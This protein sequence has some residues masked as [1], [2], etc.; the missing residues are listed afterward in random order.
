MIKA[1]QLSENQM[2]IKTEQDYSNVVNNGGVK[3]K[4]KLIG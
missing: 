3:S 4:G 2:M 1:E